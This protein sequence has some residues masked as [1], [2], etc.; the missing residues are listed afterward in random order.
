MAPVERN[1][2]ANKFDK[3]IIVLAFLVDN[4]QPSHSFQIKFDKIN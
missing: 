1:K 2:Q 4:N 3:I